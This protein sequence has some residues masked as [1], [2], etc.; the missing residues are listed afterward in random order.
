MFS[1]SKAENF[2]PRV[3]VNRKHIEGWNIYTIEAICTYMSSALV[4]EFLKKASST[5]FT[6]RWLKQIICLMI[7]DTLTKKLLKGRLSLTY[8][9]SIEMNIRNITVNKLKST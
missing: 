2:K 4:F 8:F 1:D 9:S 3:A 6:R 5:A 7:Q